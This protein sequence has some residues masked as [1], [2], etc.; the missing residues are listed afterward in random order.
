[1]LS[2]R[3]LPASVRTSGVSTRPEVMSIS[4]LLSGVT[5]GYQRPPS[6]VR[7]EAPQV[8]RGIE[9]M[10]L[11]DAVELLV[12]VA[13]GD[14]HPA[15]EEMREAA[16]EDVEAGVDVDRRLRARRRIPHRR[17]RVVL[18]RVRLGRVVADRVVGQHLAVRQ[19]RDVD[20]DDRPVDD[21]TP[22][23][24]VLRAPAAAAAAVRAALR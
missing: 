15:V 24:H 6:H 23:A 11:D 3:R 14:E 8:R 1:M 19:Q 9:D 18:H 13:A 22:L 20:A 7:A 4:P 12:L 21:R 16:A 10:R 17:A 5:V 2:A